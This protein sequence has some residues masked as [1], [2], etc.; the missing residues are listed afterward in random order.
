MTNPP[1]DFA[2]SAPPRARRVGWLLDRLGEITA[3]LLALLIAAVLLCTAISLIT[4]RWQPAAIAA[5]AAAAALLL[6]VATAL[7]ERAV[8]GERSLR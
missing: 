5:T 2:P 4:D 1:I 7:A 3:K 6:G 8:L